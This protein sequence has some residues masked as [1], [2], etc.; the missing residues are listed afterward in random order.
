MTNV[1]H[2][3][4]K[5]RSTTKAIKLIEAER[6]RQIEHGY[7]AAHDDNHDDGGAVRALM[8]NLGCILLLYPIRGGAVVVRIAHTSFYDFVTSRHRCPSNWFV[9]AHEA[10]VQLGSRCF[11][12]MATALRRDI[13]RMGSP[14]VTN[15]DVTS[16]TIYRYIVTGLRYACSHAFMHVAGDNG[17]L[18][19]LET[20]LME[21]LLE[22][23]EAMSLM[24]HLDA[25]V[26]LMQHA[27]TDLNHVCVTH[28][29]S[30][31]DPFL[32][33][34]PALCLISKM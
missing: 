11:S 9:D 24:R 27:L 32:M 12:L 18:R 25:A 3:A 31:R 17:N 16:E 20:F 30:F 7:D 19:M 4:T 26:E 21:K 2:E 13:C 34:S 23:L 28:S 15:S 29:Y 22:W 14:S 1:N 33:L 8:E 6:Q 10:S 5:A